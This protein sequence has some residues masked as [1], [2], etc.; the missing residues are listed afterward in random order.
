MQRKF[1][2]NSGD[3]PPKGKQVLKSAALS[4]ARDK[5]CSR[6]R[7]IPDG[8]GRTCAYEFRSKYGLP[9]VLVGRYTQP[10]GMDGIISTQKWLLEKTVVKMHP[11]IMHIEKVGLVVFHPGLCIR[12]NIGTNHRMGE[13]YLNFL[14]GQGILWDAAGHLHEIWQDLK[15]QFLR[16]MGKDPLQ[17]KLR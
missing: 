11:L 1:N 14:V 9:F 3:N 6:I 8:Y 13:I 5:G 2:L 15:K 10:W 4:L 17:N 12:L 16:S 7:T